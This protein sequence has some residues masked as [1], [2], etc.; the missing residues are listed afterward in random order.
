MFKAAVADCAIKLA[1]ARAEL[2]Y[3]GP[4]LDCEFEPIAVLSHGIFSSKALSIVNADSMHL[5]VI[6][7]IACYFF[8][9]F[10]SYRPSMLLS[11]VIL[12]RST[13]TVLTKG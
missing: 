1:V 2:R 8:I 12:Q 6:T 13:R 4:S 11:P 3:I 10:R 7:K 5:K 9:V